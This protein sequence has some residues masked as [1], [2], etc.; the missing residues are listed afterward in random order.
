M[1]QTNNI[2]KEELDLTEDELNRIFFGSDKSE[3]PTGEPK[4]ESTDENDPDKPKIKRWKARRTKKE[5]SVIPPKLNNLNKTNKQEIKNPHGRPLKWTPEKIEQLKIEKALIA[6]QK[7]LEK[8]EKIKISK[9]S[10]NEPISI[11]EKDKLFETAIRTKDEIKKHLEE[12]R[13]I[14]K[15]ILNTNHHPFLR[16]TIMCNHIYKLHHFDSIGKV[17]T[18]CNKCSERKEMTMNQ[19]NSYIA[20]NR[21]KL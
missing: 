18:V 19:W 9:L 3:K 13:T 14:I 17:I 8:A 11:Y 4:N 5:H 12:K 6:K 20:K 2:S 15:E 21:K 16:S 10:T 1:E 7:R